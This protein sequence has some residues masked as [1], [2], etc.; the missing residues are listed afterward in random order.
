MQSF[1]AILQQ[2]TPEA[3]QSLDL[4]EGWGQGRALFGGITAAIAWQH[5][6]AGAASDQQ[7]RSMTV[8]FVAPVLAGSAQ[9]KRR[10]LRRGKNV[11]QVAV[12]I[13]QQEAVVL[14]ALLSYGRARPSAIQV[15]DTPNPDEKSLAQGQRFPE[16]PLVPEFTRAFDYRVTIG[17]LPFCGSKSREFGGYMRFRELDAPITAGLLLGL[18]DAWPPALLTHLTELTP[19]SSLTWT[20]EFPTTLP[21]RSSHDWWHYVATIDYAADG[22]GHTHAHIWDESGELVAISRQTVTVF[23]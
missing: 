1:D 22:Y 20:I 3:E 5:A 18:V 16:G 21:Q 17:G 8:S 4:P 14:S 2:I 7:L 6:A 19:A 13:V 12:D 10:I 9:L 11:T 23:G 15:T